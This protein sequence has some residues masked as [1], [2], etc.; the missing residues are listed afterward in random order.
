METNIA[1]GS[2]SPLEG[3]PIDCSVHFRNNLSQALARRTRAP[4][5]ACLL[6]GQ[7]AGE[8]LRRMIN[9]RKAR[10]FLKMPFLCA[11][12]RLDRF[13]VRRDA[14]PALGLGRPAHPSRYPA[15]NDLWWTPYVE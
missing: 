8:P 6:G 4:P 14:N 3:D 10:R 7:P 12:G 2:A 1:H 15:S 11:S 13:W 9:D 5:R